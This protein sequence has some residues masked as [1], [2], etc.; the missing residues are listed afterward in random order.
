V[1]KKKVRSFL[2]FFK[3]NIFY[4]IKYVVLNA[5]NPKFNFMK[6]QKK[7][8]VFSTP[9]SGNL[10]DQAIAYAQMNFIKTYYSDYCYVELSLQEVYS[11]A[12]NLRKSI[13][14][15]DILFINGGGNIGDEYYHEEYT[16]RFIIKYFK[17]S[18]IISFPQTIH[19]SDTYDGEKAFEKSKKIFNENNNFKLIAR[20]SRS[21][22]I[23]KQNFDTS[24]ILYTPDIVLS[25]DKR[26]TSAI[27]N[28]AIICLRDD[29]EGKLDKNFKTLLEYVLKKKFNK[30]RYFDT[31]IERKL[32]KS[33]RDKELNVIWNAFSESEVVI[34]D[35]LHGM[36]FCAITG[37]PCIAFNNYN[38][39]IKFSYLNWLNKIP[40]I[41]YVDLDEDRVSEKYIE[42]IIDE[43]KAVETDEHFY[44]WIITQYHPLFQHM[45]QIISK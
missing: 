4:Y 44:E 37:T 21:Y 29:I 8:I 41:K 34:T 3:I 14:I 24:K 20:E 11:Y 6:D 25:L 19:F 36:I 42:K 5:H 15:H 39:K 10:G 35:R 16:R 2:E 1:V 9:I 30:T 33:T 45:E 32:N 13:N 40:N 28:G 27:R 22:E 26:R 31:D 23:M 12:K 17:K 43:I 18:N 7:I 38:H